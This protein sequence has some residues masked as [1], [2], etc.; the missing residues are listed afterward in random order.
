MTFA[1][2]PFADE[3]RM[4]ALEEETAMHSE[5]LKILSKDFSKEELDFFGIDKDGRTPEMVQADTE[6]ENMRQ[7]QLD[8]DAY[9]AC[10]RGEIL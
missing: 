4:S 8:A 1:E 6:I 10:R 7:L 3:A 9:A 2:E 5:T